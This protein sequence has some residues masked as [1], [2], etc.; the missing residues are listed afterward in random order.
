MD[1][2]SKFLIMI[3]ILGV[4]YTLGATYYRFYIVRDYNLIAEIECDPSINSCFVWEDED[5]EIW[6][7][8]LIEKKAS[9]V[10]VCNPHR[11]ECEELSCEDDE[12][13]CEIIF[14]DVN[15]LDEGEECI[16]PGL[17]ED[18]KLTD[19]EI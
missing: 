8:N 11:E 14:C 5:G 10:S 4:F 16:G 3:F 1:K 7:Y 6:Y 15:D 2:K 19:I 9:N 18:Y 17:I 12:E 13:G